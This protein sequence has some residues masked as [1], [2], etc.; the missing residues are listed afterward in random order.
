[1][2]DGSNFTFTVIISVDVIIFIVIIANKVITP[3]NGMIERGIEREW[4]FLSVLLTTRT[5]RQWL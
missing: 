3:R 2:H 4:L 1:M 5:V